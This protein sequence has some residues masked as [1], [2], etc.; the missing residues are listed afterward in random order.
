[1]GR[2]AP[3]LMSPENYSVGKETQLFWKQKCTYLQ[4]VNVTTTGNPLE[5]V[6][7]LLNFFHHCKSKTYTLWDNQT[8]EVCKTT[9]FLFSPL[10]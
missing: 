6:I 4:V 9:Y 5:S 10:S 3:H 2:K 1:M 7:L 8:L